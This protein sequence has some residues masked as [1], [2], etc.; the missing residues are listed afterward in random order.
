MSPRSVPESQ[1]VT[2]RFSM[3][4][5]D[6]ILRSEG[7]DH[8]GWPGGSSGVTIGR[9]YDLGYHTAEQFDRDWKERLPAQQY[10]L[11]RACI[12]LTGEKARDKARALR[13]RI[14]IAPSS[15]D[16]VFI[17]RTLPRSIE[18]ARDVFPG[19]DQLPLDAQGALVSLVF[20][21]GGRLT[22]RDPALQ[23]RREMRAIKAA[24]AR[25]DLREI[26]LQIRSMKRLWMNQGL[27]GLLKRRDEEAELVEKSAASDNASREVRY[28]S[29]P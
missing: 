8:G 19:I 7:L 21:R 15:A 12:G 16:M 26:A 1:S 10:H 6:L 13:G 24:V 27:N 20:N 14:N 11:L 22:D 18:L 29:R 2:R 5:L 28:T 9:G 4:A 17:T 25:G 23:E 3:R